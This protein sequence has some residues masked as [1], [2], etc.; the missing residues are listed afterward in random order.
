MVAQGVDASLMTKFV[1]DAH[2]NNVLALVTIGGWSGSVYWSTS[3]ASAQ[4][5]TTF[6]TNVVQFAQQ[7]G[8]D[9]VDFEYVS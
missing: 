4:N 2:A 8:F 3:V 9:G 5:R 1:S 6:A 7:Y